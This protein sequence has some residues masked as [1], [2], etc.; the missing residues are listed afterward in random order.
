[1]NLLFKKLSYSH[2][3]VE[4]NKL[5][6]DTKT[7]LEEVK[8]NIESYK[9]KSVINF[10]HTFDL[11]EA[12][13]LYDEPLFI[14]RTVRKDLLE[15]ALSYIFMNRTQEN[16]KDF[17][18]F[19]NIYL[20]DNGTPQDYIFNNAINDNHL[21]QVEKQ[22]ILDFIKLKRNRETLW[23]KY[24]S[25]YETQTIYYEDLYNGV[26]VP[27]LELNNIYFG[28]DDSTIKLPYDK[29]SLFVNYN[30]IEEWIYEANTFN[31]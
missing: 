20:A 4:E 1:M 5:N 30:E 26:D 29:K 31:N 2:I 7:L 14:L 24:S 22:E 10:T 16:H 13:E 15:Q 11:L 27:Q 6:L 3:Y 19:P 12:L 21:I 17:Y 28:K 9:N 25:K 23:K 8:F 18:R